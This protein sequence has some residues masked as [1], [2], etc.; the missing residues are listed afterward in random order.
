M[1]DSFGTRPILENILLSTD[2][3]A[4]SLMSERNMNA[5]TR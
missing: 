3:W 2:L 4:R 1:K 5:N